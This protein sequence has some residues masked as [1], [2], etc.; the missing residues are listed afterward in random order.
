MDSTFTIRSESIRVERPVI[1]GDDLD[2]ESDASCL[3][4]AESG[5][6]RR[7]AI[8]R[9]MLSEIDVQTKLAAQASADCDV[10][11]W[12]RSLN[13]KDQSKY[14]ALFAEHEVDMESLKLM[15]ADQLKEM[16]VTALGTLNKMVHSIG[17]LNQ[18]ATKG[19]KSPLSVRSK[20]Q[21]SVATKKGAII[22]R[23]I[24][25]K[26]QQKPKVSLPKRPASAHSKPKTISK[27]HIHHAFNCRRND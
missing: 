21:R 7:A 18:K 6:E 2:A 20:E 25:A 1:D 3:S 8:L 11:Q 22:V 10:V 26:R 23:P 19:T 16:G 24:S 14:I 17:Q 4:D 9:H 27:S 15:S 12:I 13:V 5:A